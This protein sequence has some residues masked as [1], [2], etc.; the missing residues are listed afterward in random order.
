L[1][2]ADKI[3]DASMPHQMFMQKMVHAYPIAD[4]VQSSGG[5]DP[6]DKR[7]TMEQ[8]FHEASW[9]HVPKGYQAP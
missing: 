4:S 7:E 8:R 2:T 5:C 9:I 6:E 3:I 1:P